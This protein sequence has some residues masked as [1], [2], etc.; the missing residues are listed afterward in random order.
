MVAPALPLVWSLFYWLLLVAVMW[1]FEGL[2]TALASLVLRRAPYAV[3]LCVGAVLGVIMMRPLHAL[4]QGLF[5][6]L[7][8]SPAAMKT[9][10]LF[11][12]TFDDWTLLFSWNSPLMAFWIGGALFFSF[13][14]GYAPFKARGT[15]ED[16]LPT[17]ASSGPAPSVPRFAERLT[18][19][20]FDEV[21]AIQ[22]EDH[23]IRCFAGAKEELL[24]YRFADAVQDLEAHDWLRIHRSSCVHRGRIARVER[25]GRSL[26]VTMQSGRT[27]AVSERY[28]ALVA[29]S[30]AV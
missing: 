29:Q 3:T 25:H 13:F 19:L 16:L 26:V 17:S 10:P 11:P 14:V 6:P 1:L 23:Y 15:V 8:A 20:S 2:G 28:H 22:A 27:F 30:V 5:A 21:E 7:V 18:R 4:Y 12:R 9:L 24:L